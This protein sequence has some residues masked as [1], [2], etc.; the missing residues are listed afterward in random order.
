MKIT[1]LIGYMGSGKSTI[2]RKLANKLDIGFI[3]LDKYIEEKE[4]STIAEIFEM[5]GEAEFR[6]IEQQALIEVSKLENKVISLGGGTPCFF[7]NMEIIN[8]SGVSVYLKMPI[9]MLV[10]RL[11]NAK[12]QRPLIKGMNREELFSFIE[13]QLYEREKFYS[14]SSVVFDASR[15][16]IRVLKGIIL[17]NQ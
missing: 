4:S 5:K 7:D 17:Q 6:K 16:D 12:V 11:I 1:Y 15:N 9:G 13:E 3:D 8:N 10:S 14:L 2:G